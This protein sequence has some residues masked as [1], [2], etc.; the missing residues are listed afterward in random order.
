M[1]T[2]TY[3]LFMFLLFHLHVFAG[4]TISI[5]N[6][7]TLKPVVRVSLPAASANSLE[8]K[9]LATAPEWLTIY[10]VVDGTVAD[11]PLAGD[12]KLNKGQLSFTPYNTLGYGLQFEVQYKNGGAVVERKRFTMPVAPTPGDAA[13]VVTGYPLADT[14]PYNT[15]FFHV[16]F[17]QPMME[18]QHAYNY[19]KVLDENGTERKNAWRQRSFW[20]DEGRLLVLMIHPGRVKNGIHYES[21]LFDLGKRYT[22][23]VGKDIKDANGNPLA[24]AYTRAYYVTAE[25]RKRP[26]VALDTMRLPHHGSSTPLGISFS[27]GMDYASVWNGV[28]VTDTRGV[29]VPVRVE[30]N[31]NDNKYTITP[32][33]SWRKGS[34]TLLLKSAVYDFAAN[35]INRLFEIKEDSEMEKDKI[36]T[37]WMFEI[38]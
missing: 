19:I 26:Q 15:L 7:A 25:D 13:E 21:P 14:I 34:Y 31:G 3:F 9:G 22:I 16:R 32:E 6:L 20:L 30:T 36:V 27:E 17:S 18:D 2:R 28:S 4:E 38:E 35:R 29:Q 11:I 37:T 12:Y 1:H 10:M 23:R 8:Q 33:Q 5:T 24:S